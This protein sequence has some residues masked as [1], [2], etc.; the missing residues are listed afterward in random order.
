MIDFLL[1]LRPTLCLGAI[2]ALLFIGCA[3]KDAPSAAADAVTLEIKDYDAIMA[4]LKQQLGKVVVMDAWSTSC[5]PCLKEFP[6]LVALS[7]KHSSERLACISLSFDYEGLGTPESQ[8]P[9]VLAFLRSQGATFQN[10]ISSTP[11]DE[12]YAKLKLSSIPA[13]YVYDR[14]GQLAKRFDGSK[15]FTYSDVAAKVNELLGP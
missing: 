15:P 4:T 6:G 2:V 1:R 12:L 5:E 14:Q 9:K 13:V 3:K 8:T 11:S 7:K 10:L